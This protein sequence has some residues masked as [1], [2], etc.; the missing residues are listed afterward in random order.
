MSQYVLNNL[1]RTRIKAP[2]GVKKELD[3]RI[4]GSIAPQASSTISTS[5][6]IHVSQGQYQPINSAALKWGREH[7]LWHLIT[8]SQSCWTL[9]FLTNSN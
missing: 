5:L 8:V 3:R 9:V 1:L 6:I 2:H 7:K 4:T